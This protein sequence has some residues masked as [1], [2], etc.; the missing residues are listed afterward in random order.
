MSETTDRILAVI[1]AGLQTP[2]PDPTFG[3]ISPENDDGCTRCGVW[4]DVP[5][6]PG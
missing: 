4:L 5:E 2:E 3:E 6:S 1:D